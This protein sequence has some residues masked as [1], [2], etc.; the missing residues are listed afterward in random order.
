[1]LTLSWVQRRGAHQAVLEPVSHVDGDLLFCEALEHVLQHDVCN[2]AN[3][4]LVELAED[5]DLVQAVQELGPEVLLQ[6]LDI[7]GNSAGLVTHMRAAF[8]RADAPR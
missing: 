8:H 2:L 3:L 5:D 7:Y 6:L 4:A 1:M